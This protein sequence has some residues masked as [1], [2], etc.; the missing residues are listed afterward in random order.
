MAHREAKE[1]CEVKEVSE[2]KE[3]NE[4]VAAFFDLDGTLMP[5]PSLEKRFFFCYAIER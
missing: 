5:G 4:G 3:K 1:E 2:V